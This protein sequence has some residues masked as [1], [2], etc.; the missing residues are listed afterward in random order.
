MTKG[1]MVN[2]MN[3][4]DGDSWHSFPSVYAVGHAALA[5]LFLD[6]VIVEEKVDGSQFSFGLF[7]WREMSRICFSQRCIMSRRFP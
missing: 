3:D 7:F 4:Q 2:N 5:D 1:G 6:D